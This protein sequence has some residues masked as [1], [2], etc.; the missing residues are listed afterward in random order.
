MHVDF[1]GRT[2]DFERANIVALQHLMVVD[3]YVKEHKEFIKQK[4]AG[5]GQVRTDEDVIK[6]HNS[7][8]TNW[9]REKILENPPGS[10]ASEKRNS[11]SPCHRAPRTT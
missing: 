9:F 6:E 5:R 3:R 11:Y 2:K 1:A 10:D 8:F 4:Y 7:S